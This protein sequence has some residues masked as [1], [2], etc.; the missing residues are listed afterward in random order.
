MKAIATPYAVGQNEPSRPLAKL[1]DIPDDVTE[2]DHML[3]E[4]FFTHALGM[5]DDCD[6]PELTIKEGWND[7]YGNL[8]VYC[9]THE[10]FL[11]LVYVDCTSD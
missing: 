5:E 8:T 9:A 7:R 10:I 3:T 1:V 6:R 11:F 4:L 2:R